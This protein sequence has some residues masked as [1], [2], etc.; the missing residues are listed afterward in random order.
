V[1]VVHLV[2][3]REVAPLRERW[4]GTLAGLRRT[5]LRAPLELATVSFSEALSRQL[6]LLRL[7]ATGG[8]PTHFT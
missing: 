1:L 7:R 3:R 4:R 2:V 5:P 8:L 6:G